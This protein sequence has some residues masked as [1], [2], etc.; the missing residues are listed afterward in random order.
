MFLVLE[1]GNGDVC[2]AGLLG[3]LHDYDQHFVRRFFVGLDDDRALRVLRMQSFDVRTETAR[4]DLAP[5]DPDL[6]VAADGDQDGGVF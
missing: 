5:V 4:L 6:V 2:D 3:R 1:R